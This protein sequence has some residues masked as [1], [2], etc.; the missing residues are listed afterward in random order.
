[1]AT[2]TAWF[3]LTIVGYPQKQLSTNTNGWAV[4][5]LLF[6]KYRNAACKDKHGVFAP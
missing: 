5:V 3:L 2:F 1:M 4:F 6:V